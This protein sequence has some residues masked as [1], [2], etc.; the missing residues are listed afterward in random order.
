[1]MDVRMVRSIELIYVTGCV[2]IRNRMTWN[3]IS[4]TAPQRNRRNMGFLVVSGAASVFLYI[5]L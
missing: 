1:M 4:G 3:L 5:A 2:R